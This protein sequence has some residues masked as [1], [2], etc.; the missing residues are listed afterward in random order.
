MNI[1]NLGSK[2]SITSIT[3]SQDGFKSDCP[4]KSSKQS[5]FKSSLKK[6][7][8]PLPNSGQLLPIKWLSI[9][10][11][12][13]GLIKLVIIKTTYTSME[14]YPLNYQRQQPLSLILSLIRSPCLPSFHSPLDYPQH[15]SEAFVYKG[16]MAES[17]SKVFSQQIWMFFI[18][19]RTPYETLCSVTLDFHESYFSLMPGFVAVGENDNGHFLVQWA[20]YFCLLSFFPAEGKLYF[21]FFELIIIPELS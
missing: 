16:T 12:I 18:H 19:Q 2:E 1:L 6:S 21:F 4:E 8:S 20:V 3:L 13:S 9:S 11:P 17:R 7:R 10:F 15:G 14:S 5:L